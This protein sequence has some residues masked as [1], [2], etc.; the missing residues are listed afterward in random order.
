MKNKNNS[1]IIGP[2]IKATG[3]KKISTEQILK[4]ILFEKNKLELF[5]IHYLYIKKIRAN[6][7]TS[8]INNR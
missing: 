4:R 3:N 1:A 2:A 7:I 6:I 5:D 8:K